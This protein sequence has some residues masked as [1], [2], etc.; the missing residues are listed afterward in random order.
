[1]GVDVRDAQHVRREANLRR[2]RVELALV[3]AHAVLDHRQPPIADDALRVLGAHL[4]Q[5]LLKTV[6]Q[7]FVCLVLELASAD[8]Q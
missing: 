3:L 8:L 1:M 5:L 2:L 7:P 4:A 6:A